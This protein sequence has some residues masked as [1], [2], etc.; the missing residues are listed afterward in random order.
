MKNWCGTLGPVMFFWGG[1]FDD[2][3]D[4]F[5]WKHTPAF[6]KIYQYFI[7]V[8]C[9]SS[10]VVTRNEKTSFVSSTLTVSIVMKE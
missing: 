5:F 9:F 2:E 10:S 6:V 7:T 8:L 3:D 4:F 1:G